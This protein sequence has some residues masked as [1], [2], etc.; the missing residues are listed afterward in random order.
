MAA[1]PESQRTGFENY[2]YD[3]TNPHVDV[4]MPDIT[5]HNGTKIAGLSYEEPI[6]A[7]TVYVEVPNYSRPSGFRKGVRDQVWENAKGP[8][9]HVKD[10]LTG[11]VMNKNEAWDMGHKPGYEFRKSQQSAQER[12][13]SRKKFLDEYNTPDNYRPE[14]P[15][16]NRSHKGE[17]MTDKYFGP[18]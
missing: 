16:S 7:G 3:I 18:R 6:G 4:K 15:S 13:I 17:D 8:D 2:I 12:G 11:K 14:L 5:L 9:G 10:P 1:K